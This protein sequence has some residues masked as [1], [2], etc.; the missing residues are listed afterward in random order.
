[1]TKKQIYNALILA[2]KKLSEHY[3]SCPADFCG[4]EHP[5]G[6][7]NCGTE[8][9]GGILECGNCWVTYFLSEVDTCKR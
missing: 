7:N 8:I 5:D 9:N 1:M 4:W 2:C 3:T 6:C